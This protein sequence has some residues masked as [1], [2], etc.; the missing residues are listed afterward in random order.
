MTPRR[1]ITATVLGAAIFT[2]GG[3]ALEKY[4]IPGKPVPIDLG[5]QK[6]SIHLPSINEENWIKETLENLTTQPLYRKGDIKLI[7]LDSYSTDRT[8]EIAKK[9]ADEIWMTPRGKLTTRDLGFK[10]DDA[11][12]I[13]SV[14]S[15][16]TYPRGWLSRLLKPF[17]KKDVIATHG[18]IL[19]KDWLWKAPNAWFNLIRPWT[20]ISARNSAIKISAYEKTGGFNLSIDQLDRGAMV[21]EEEQLFLRKLKT[22]G[23][24]KYS[25]RAGIYATQRHRFYTTQN[26]RVPE[27]QEQIQ[28]GIRF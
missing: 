7:V 23:N 10:K 14:D 9:Y 4:M 25:P 2:G 19:S 22:L 24:V 8:V 28:K 27:Y 1:T 26:G 15:G 5:N 3:L 17:E 18:P 20:V 11:D 12:I 6:V 21:Q 16:D 13:V